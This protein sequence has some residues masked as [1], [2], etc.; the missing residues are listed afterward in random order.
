MYAVPRV[1]PP[2]WRPGAASGSTLDG[3]AAAQRDFRRGQCF[4]LSRSAE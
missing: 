1:I 4:S 3:A 2:G